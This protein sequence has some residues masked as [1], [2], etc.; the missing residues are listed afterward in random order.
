ME[1]GLKLATRQLFTARIHTIVSSIVSHSKDR[2]GPK[3]KKVGHLTL[4]TPPRAIYLSLASTCHDP[5][6]TYQRWDTSNH[7]GGRTH[8]QTNREKFHSHS[9]KQ[10]LPV[11]CNRGLVK[12]EKF[13]KGN[14]VDSVPDAC[15]GKDWLSN[16]VSVLIYMQ[17]IR[18][19]M[20]LADHQPSTISISSI[21]QRVLMTSTVGCSP[22]VNTNTV[23]ANRGLSHSWSGVLLFAGNVD[24]DVL[25]SG[26]GLMM[27]L[28]RQPCVIM[29]LSTTPTSVYTI[30]CPS[31][32]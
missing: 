1:I 10:Y 17:T 2:R 4:T 18:R 12:V 22:T 5:S 28:R 11:S 30:A 31:D 6:P 3:F 23:N 21:C 15:G 32:S 16:M 7:V 27:S 13:M 20:A 14:P 24:F 26:L 9:Q 29:T 25:H 19:H 8:G